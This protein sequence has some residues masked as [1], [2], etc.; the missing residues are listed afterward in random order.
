MTRLT[1]GMRELHHDAVATGGFWPSLPSL[2][3]LLLLI[4]P[5][6]I[7]SPPVA[8]SIMVTVLGL[9]IGFLL[10]YA[11]A[12]RRRSTVFRTW[13]LVATW[14]GSLALGILIG[15]NVFYMVIFI[16]VIHGVVLPWATARWAI[17]ALTVIGVVIP[18][19]DENW[20]PAL[21]A[22]VGAAIAIALS[23][24]LDK[25]L[26]RERLIRAENRNAVLAVAAERERIGRD[27]HDILGHSLTTITVSAQLGSRLIEVDPAA[28]AEQFA[29]IERI[30]R[31]ALAD[32][33]ATS[34]NMQ[35]VRVAT[36]IAS[37]LSVL[38]AAGITAEVPTAIPGLSDDRAEL[39]GY[40]VREA[41]TNI[42]RHSGAS[43]C[44][45]EVSPAEV[46]IADDGR[47]LPSGVG[48]GSS[49]EA[50]ARDDSRETFP[51]EARE[52]VFGVRVHEGGAISGSGIAGLRRRVEAACGELIVRR[53]AQDPMSADGAD[54][55]GTEVIARMMS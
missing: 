14:I 12:A 42:V 50:A 6:W 17:P 43:R 10:L 46:R 11:S 49:P 7:E 13:W 34:A 19:L 32:V 21:L 47:G 25:A 54:R 8:V 52:T 51:G 31:Q 37:A 48:S 33:R 5:T 3:F 9:A 2:L 27:L 29:Q 53:L 39:F 36:E 40:V 16:L 26:L 38:S 23:I 1:A 4:V 24:G 30:S 15:Q 18:A 22:V 55:P 35:H 20:I 45:I 41:V 28:A 44:R